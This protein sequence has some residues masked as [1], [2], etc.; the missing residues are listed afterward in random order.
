MRHATCDMRHAT[1]DMRHATCDMRHATRVS[2]GQSTALRRPHG[3][4]ETVCRL[5]DLAHPDLYLNP[6]W[7]IQQNTQPI[8]KPSDARTHLREH[9]VLK[10]PAAKNRHLPHQI[11]IRPVRYPPGSAAARSAGDTGRPIARRSSGSG[12]SPRGVVAHIG[13]SDSPFESCL[14]ADAHA[15]AISHPLSYDQPVGL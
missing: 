13:A 2:Q 7:R 9:H 3:P 6:I 10:H 14:L 5:H 1:C 12:V 8:L 4:S 15:V 11:T